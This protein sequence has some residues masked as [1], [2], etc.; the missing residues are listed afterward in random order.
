M[1][2]FVNYALDLFQVE[3]SHPYDPKMLQFTLIVHIPL[4]SNANRL[5]HYKFLLL[6]IH[7]NFTANI[8]IAPDVRQNHLLAIGHSKSIQTI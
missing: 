5:E 1:V 6:P 4:I 8:S 3:V 2:S 7:F